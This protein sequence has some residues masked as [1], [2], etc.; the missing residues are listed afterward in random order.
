MNNKKEWNVHARFGTLSDYF[1][2]LDRSL[3]VD[4]KSLPVLSGDFF[5]YSDRDD[6]YWS[7]Y[8]T[9][10]PF[11]KQMD[12]TLLHQL[13][14]AEIAF[15]LRSMNGGSLYSSAFGSL[16]EARRALSLFQHHDGVT[17]TAKD[18]VMKDYGNKF[19]VLFNTLSR[20]R[21]EPVCIRVDSLRAAVKAPNGK[22]IR[23][24]LSPVFEL[25]NSHLVASKN[26]E[27]CFVDQ[28]NAFGVSVYE[29]IEKPDNKGS[30][31]T[32]MAASNSAVSGFDFEAIKG[33]KFLLK[34][35]Q[36]EAIFS[37]ATGFLQSVLPNNHRE[38]VVDLHFVH[39]GARDNRKK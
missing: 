27:L 29:V 25:Q 14:A 4:Q 39:Y 32:V 12:R 34:N 24:Q 11:Y 23:Q 8:F 30:L 1:A 36:L 35:E 37:A 20:S 3:R 2:E 5:T 21:N 6:H 15:S 22:E 16:V 10:R 19:V 7:G 38:I 33:E 13:R 28:L 31:A 26:Y 18:Y 9:S 17:G